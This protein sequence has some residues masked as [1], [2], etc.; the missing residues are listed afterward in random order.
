MA[1]EQNFLLGQ[2]ERLTGPV[3]VTRSGGPKNPPYDFATARSR[4]GKKLATTSATLDDT[5]AEACPNNEV[6]AVVTMHPRYVS[7]SDFP[8]QLFGAVGLRAVGSRARSIEPERWGIEKH[9][10]LALGEDYFVA[11]TKRAFSKWSTNLPNWSATSPGAEDLSHVEDVSPLTASEK[12]RSIPADK[13]AALF[14]VVVHE[15]TDQVLKAFEAYATKHGG[16]ALMQRARHVKGLAFIP[17]RAPSSRVQEI[18]AFSF[19]RVLRGMP[20]LRPFHPGI[21]RGQDGFDVKLPAEDALNPKVRA[22]VF[23]GG[24][25]P[26]VDLSRWVR[27]AEPSGIGAAVPEYMAHGLAVTTALLFGP[28]AK[29]V[30]P[31]RPLCS[32]DHVR[33]LDARS[34]VD[35]VELLYVDVLERILGTLDRDGA[36]YDFVNISLGPRLA[37]TDDEITAWTA[38]LDER[39]ARLRLVATVAAGNDGELDSVSRLNRIQPP[40]DAVNVVAVGAV[41]QTV[42]GWAR[43]PYSCVGPGRSPGIMKPDGMAFGGSDQEPFMVLAPTKS[44]TA[45]GQQGTSFAAPFA[46]RSAVGLRVQL[47][48]AIGPLAIRALMIHRADMC[49]H[50]HADVGWGR[51]EPDHDSLITT[52]DDEAIVIYQG[53]LPVGEHLRAEIPM[54]KDKLAGRVTIGATLVISPQVDPSH[55]SAY[56]RSGLEISF[57]PHAKKHGMSQGKRSAHPKTKSFFSVA[58]MYGA[59]EYDLRDDGH[60][61]EPCL[62]NVQSFLPTS[63]DRPC[64]DIYYH[65]RKAGSKAEDPQPIQYA[66][67]VGIRAPKTQ[68]LYDRVVRAYANILVPLRP[69]VRVPIRTR[70]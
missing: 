10:K 17:V 51:F 53:D 54:P 41:D 18:A 50:G 29:A 8:T 4:V 9:P 27:T 13:E 43:A 23:D 34:G 11:G 48:E 33:V 24:I 6:V 40:A 1:R 65:H 67:I 46:L 37:I 12:L 62:R 47:G 20:S 15:A 64:F 35:D 2:G 21:L 5:P 42:D 44:P 14:E 70:T 56:T 69:Q 16:E 61:W 39:F 57:R 31:S 45:I 52:A 36:S 38:S 25:P 32:V 19:V 26:Q 28:L 55:P 60:K 68:D 3:K 59:P 58:K 63:L 30:S 22:L 7:K 49:D 66:L